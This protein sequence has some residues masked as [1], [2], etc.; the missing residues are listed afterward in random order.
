V[1]LVAELF[2]QGAQLA[3]RDAEGVLGGD[4]VAGHAR[5]P[6]GIRERPQRGEGLVGGH[7]RP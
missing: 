2:R 4:A 3:D 5:Q 1:V 6:R 7:V